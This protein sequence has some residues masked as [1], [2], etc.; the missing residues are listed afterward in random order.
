MP[1]SLTDTKIWCH[2]ASQM[3]TNIWGHVASQMVTKMWCHVASQMVTKVW[4][5]VSS[6]MVSNMMLCSLTDTKIGYHVASQ[7]V[8][9]MWGHAAPHFGNQDM[10]WCCLTD[11][12]L[13]TICHTT[14][15]HNSLTIYQTNC[16]EM[17][18]SGIFFVSNGFSITNKWDFFCVR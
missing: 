3:V 1:C 14:W 15:C 17:Q 4:R 18:S 13:L 5:R 10:M 8:T 12:Y 16:S 6:Q 2:V 11:G 7:M 9:I